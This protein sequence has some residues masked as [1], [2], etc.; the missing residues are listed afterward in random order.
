MHQTWDS[1][2]LN[3][4]SHRW[5][6]LIWKY[7]WNHIKGLF[8]NMT[9]ETIRKIARHISEIAFSSC[10][11]F[12]KFRQKNK[13]SLYFHKDDRNQFNNLYSNHLL[14]AI[15]Q[16]DGVSLEFHVKSNVKMSLMPRIW[17]GLSRTGLRSP[18]E[19][20]CKP[21]CLKT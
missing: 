10:F 13:I 3:L 15:A 18:S 6:T 8:L 20:K 14:A 17:Y 19:L 16:F 4:N 21:Y 1:A 5:I 9:E 2:Q 12:A 11:Y 7:N